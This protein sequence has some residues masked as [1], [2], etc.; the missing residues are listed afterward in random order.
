MTL[1]EE[2]VPQGPGRESKYLKDL[3]GR[4]STSRTWKGE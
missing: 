1:K 2:K 4:V 3:E